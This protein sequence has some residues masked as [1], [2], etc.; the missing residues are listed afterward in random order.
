MCKRGNQKI[1]QGRDAARKRAAPSFESRRF[2]AFE[3]PSSEFV[4]TKFTKFARRDLVRGC[5]AHAAKR[6]PRA[7]LGLEFHYFENR[8]TLSLGLT[9]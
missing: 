8:I 9:D 4:H 7:D 1:G 6:Q 3:G 5:E 2:L